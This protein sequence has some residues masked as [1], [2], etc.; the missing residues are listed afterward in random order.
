MRRTLLAALLPV[1]FLTLPLPA[2][3]ILEA[4]SGGAF[5]SYNDVRIPGDTGTLFSI[6]DLGNNLS[7]FLRL[8]ATWEINGDHSLALTAAPLRLDASGFLD[9]A[10]NFAGK[11]FAQGDLVDADYRFDTYRFTWRYTL[12]DKP[13]WIVKI[14]LTGLLRDAAISLRSGTTFAESKNTG[15]VPLISFRVQWFVGDGFSLLLDGDA[16]AAPQGRA[17]DV[18]LALQYSIGGRYLFHAGWRFIEGGADNDKVYT[19]AM[20]HMLSLGVGLRL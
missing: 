3:W 12:L 5:S 8:R 18:L 7:L 2:A 1:A 17:E 6:Q 11:T 19:F 20:I 9:Q 14:G 15:F 13:D 4:E 16:L 10:V